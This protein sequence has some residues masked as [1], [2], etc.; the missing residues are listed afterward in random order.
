MGVYVAAVKAPHLDLHTE[1]MR[2]AH[3]TFISEFYTE[4]H[5]LEVMPK[6]WDSI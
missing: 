5:K 6:P 3:S 2:R 1:A 4:K